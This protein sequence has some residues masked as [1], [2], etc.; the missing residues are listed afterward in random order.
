MNDN[1]AKGRNSF[2]IVTGNVLV[3][4]FNRNS[5]E[6]PT[7]IGA[8][9]FDLVPVKQHKDLMLNSARMYAQQ[10][11]DR[12]MEMVSVLQKQADQLKRR[13]MITDAV[14]SAEYAF[15]LYPGGEYWLLFDE[16]SNCTRLSPMGPNDWATGQ[17]KY[18]QYLCRIKWLGDSTWIEVDEGNA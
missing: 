17:P 18:Y 8:P 5:T 12:I 15:K 11:Y 13:L 6:Y 3:N 2:D 14:Y 7:E 16:K 9:K 10:E 1:S 4:F